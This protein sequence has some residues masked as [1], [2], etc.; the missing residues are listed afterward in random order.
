MAN[1]PFTNSGCI[2]DGCELYY[3]GAPGKDTCSINAIPRAI[4]DLV[5]TIENN[6]S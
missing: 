1:C 2:G 6:Q 4:N 5:Q 3:K